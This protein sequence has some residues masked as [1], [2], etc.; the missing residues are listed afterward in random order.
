[1]YPMLFHKSKIMYNKS[2][3]LRANMFIYK[4]IGDGAGK[5]AVVM[6]DEGDIGAYN[7]ANR[8]MHHMIENSGPIFVLIW[9]V[10]QIFPKQAMFCTCLWGVGRM[11]HQMGY[12]TGG[13][14][15]H[16][17][18]F[19]LATVGMGTMEGLCWFVAL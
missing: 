4:M 6:E 12:A 3:N 10:G 14:G 16:G 18:G 1:M 17:I 5:G 7:R 11:W 13:Y 9:M 19:L 2:G 15:S 8:S